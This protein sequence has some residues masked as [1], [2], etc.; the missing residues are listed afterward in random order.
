MDC[1]TKL[2]FSYT[3]KNIIQKIVDNR[4]SYS[5]LTKTHEWEL[6]VHINSTIKERTLCERQC[7]GCLEFLRVS[8]MFNNLNTDITKANKKHK[9]LLDYLCKTFGINN[10]ID[11]IVL[12]LDLTSGSNYVKSRIQNNFISDYGEYEI[13]I[14]SA[15]YILALDH[16][17]HEQAKCSD[18]LMSYA[19]LENKQFI[20]YIPFEKHADQ[21]I[22]Y[23]DQNII[24]KCINDSS[25]RKQ[26]IDFK[27][28]KN[29]NS[30]TALM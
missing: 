30:F 21:K 14:N 8:R 7:L 16:Y 1:L 4:N 17:I 20:S 25:L 3:W 27:N 2:I 24:S 5:T 22:F 10:K 28:K 19:D 23:L 13:A 6:A 15:F 11:P 12:A 26:I 9:P 29:M 18:D